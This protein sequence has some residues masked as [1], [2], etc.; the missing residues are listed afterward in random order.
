MAYNKALDLI[1]AG[2]LAFKAGQFSEAAEFMTQAAEDDGFDDAVEMIDNTSEEELEGEGDVS[3]CKASFVRAAQRIAKADTENLGDGDL[4]ASDEKPE[5][6]DVQGVMRD[7]ENAVAAR[8]AR[9]NR[10]KSTLAKLSR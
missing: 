3:A 10:N 8:L 2:A 4:P 6:D 7:G 5:D 9:S 1:L